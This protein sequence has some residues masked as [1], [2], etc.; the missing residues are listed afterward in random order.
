MDLFVDKF[1]VY[2]Y[3]EKKKKWDLVFYYKD[4]EI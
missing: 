2:L 4:Y 1:Y 3:V